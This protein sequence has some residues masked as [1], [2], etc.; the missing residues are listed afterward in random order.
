MWDL[1]INLSYTAGGLGSPSKTRDERYGRVTRVLTD[2]EVRKRA[3]FTTK[4]RT[5][6]S[7]STGLVWIMFN[8]Q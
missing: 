5:T 1:Q 8:N 3:Y 2:Y 6:S 7:F 4:W